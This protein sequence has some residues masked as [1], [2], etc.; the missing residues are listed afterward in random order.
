[1]DS[2]I[3]RAAALWCGLAGVPATFES[4]RITVVTAPAA[5]TAPRG[6]IGAIRLA[7]AA[8]MTA[9]T[10]G[11]TAAVR[12][13]VAGLEPALV[14]EPAT[15]FVHHPPADVLGPTT[16]SYL[17]ES[18][19]RPVSGV[20]DAIAVGPE[21]EALETAA[22]AAD[23][24]EAGVADVMSPVFVTRAVDGSVTSACG[25]RI[26][27][28][29]I[30]H[31]CVLTHPDYRGRG[32]ATTVG[33]AATAHALA[34]GLLPQWRAIPAASIAIARSLGYTMAGA[35]LSFRL[36]PAN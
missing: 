22:G 30:A 6:W 4:G 18:R 19:F 21:I 11:L 14:C 12:N 29:A 34:A 16:L 25:Y 10:P 23:A 7:D 13:L 31:M 36:A 17:E 32:L 1:M 2:L 3:T 15:I 27:D 35:Q 33:S 24:D 28:G 26:W 9:P 8:L 5:R 20:V